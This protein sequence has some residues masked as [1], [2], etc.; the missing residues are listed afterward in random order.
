[1]AKGKYKT[2]KSDSL[3]T[4]LEKRVSNIFVPLESFIHKQVTAAALLITATIIALILAN[5]FQINPIAYIA[6]KKMGFLFGDKGFSLPV[7]EWINSGLMALFFFIIGLEIKRSVL[8]GKLKDMRHVRLIIC[9]AIGGMVVPGVLY[10]IVNYGAIGQQG[11]AIPMATDTAF[12]IGILALLTR[13]ISAEISIFL[14]ALAI[15][16]DI[17]AILIISIFYTDNLHYASLLQALIPLALLMSANK[18]GITN[19]WI[20][21]ILGATLWYFIHSSGIHGTLAGLLLALTIPART[22]ITQGSFIDKTRNLVNIFEDG[23]DKGVSMLSSKSQH[24]LTKEMHNT[25]DIASTPL[26]RWEQL[27]INPVSILI[28]PLFALFNSGIV[29]SSDTLTHILESRITLGIILGLVIG[30][31]LGIVLFGYVGIK[32]KIGTLLSG[33]SLK[34]LVGIGLMAGIGFTMSLFIATLGF[35]G[36]PELLDSAKIG[37]IVASMMSALLGATWFVVNNK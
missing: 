37:I 9:T 21:I 28:L 22:Y 6:E 10:S 34:K 7:I 1:M 33:I 16:D 32:L 11:W 13:R 14:A 15:F 4:N 3:Q 5:S 29:L 12:A 8:A 20:F 24:E 2:A 31:P 26:Q 36:R 19:G 17:G 35:E 25:M 18:M 27:F 30:K 23:E